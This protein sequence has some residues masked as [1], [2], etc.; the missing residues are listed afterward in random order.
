MLEEAAADLGARPLQGV[1]GCDPARY[2]ARVAIGVVAGVH[3][4][5]G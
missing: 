4:V 3:A 1:A 5:L 2:I